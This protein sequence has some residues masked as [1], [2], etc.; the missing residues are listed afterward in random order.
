MSE[1]FYKLIFFGLLYAVEFGCVYLYGRKAF[2]KLSATLAIG[3]WLFLMIISYY[4]ASVGGLF[5]VFL[6]IVYLLVLKKKGDNKALQQ[7]YTT[8]NIYASQQKPKAVLDALGNH[9]NWT[10]AEGTLNK[11]AGETVTY[12]FWQGYTS[13]TVSTG[14]Y[15]RSTV[16]TNY[17]AFIFPPGT[18]S[19]AFK[20]IAKAAADK[21]KRTF[22]EK[23]K[24]FFVPDYDTPILVTTAADGSFI[25]EY[26]TLVDVEYYSKRLDW[27]KENYCKMYFPVAHSLSLN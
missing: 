25:I 6:M 1:T 26:T 9:K 18:T 8:N 22:K 10:F 7:F 23:F 17:L 20:Q 3:T 13:S 2:P 12:L 27:I 15:S 19:Y 5:A 4:T 11:N 24:R 14:T 16:Y 21:S